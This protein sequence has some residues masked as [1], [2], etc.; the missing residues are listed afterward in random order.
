M[1][2]ELRTKRDASVNLINQLIRR[3]RDLSGALHASHRDSAAATEREAEPVTALSSRIRVWQQDCAVAINELSGG[4]KAHWLAR[5]FSAA[6]LVSSTPATV[7]VEADLVEIVDRLLEVLHKAGASLATI[8]DVASV[9]GAIVMRRF[10]F[11]HNVQLRPILEQAYCDSGRL[12]EQG[13][14]ELALITSCGILET[15]LTDALEHP[16]HAPLAIHEGYERDPNDGS[17]GDWSFTER[18][19][20]AERAALIRGGCARLPPIARTYREWE[21]EEP[22]SRPTV[23]ERDARLARQVLHVIMRDLDPGR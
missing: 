16:K 5:A 18:I 22:G 10:D 4:S 23:S 11:V 6:F 7:V 13:S 8:D 20:R 9:A 1:D 2:A 21:H 3:G 17:I 14:F 12:L 19:A 15:I